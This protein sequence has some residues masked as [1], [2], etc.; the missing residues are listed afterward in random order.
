MKPE[1]C[2]YISMKKLVAIVAVFLVVAAGATAQHVYKKHLRSGHAP[3]VKAILPSSHH[4]EGA[5]NI[6]D[7]QVPV[8]TEKG[9]QSKVTLEPTLPA[10][11]DPHAPARQDT[12]SWTSSNNG[13]MEEVLHQR[14]AEASRAQAGCEA[15][16]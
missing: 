5:V 8:R 16:K 1:K 15:Y 10:C 9:Q 14:Q 3:L 2:R 4:E 13:A 6:H 12:F 7:V 11:P